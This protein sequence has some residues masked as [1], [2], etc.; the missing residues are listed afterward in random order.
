MMLDLVS[1]EVVYRTPDV[2]TSYTTHH[3]CLLLV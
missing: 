3:D 2:K 1:V